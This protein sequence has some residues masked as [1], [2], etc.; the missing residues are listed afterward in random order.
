LPEA[1]LVSE[2]KGF[3]LGREGRE[4]RQV[5]PLVASD[6]QTARDLLSQALAAVQPP[7]YLDLVD[8]AAAPPGLVFQRPFTRMVR[9]AA[10]APGNEK[11]VYCV[12]GP[13]LG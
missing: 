10:P 12:A 5:G 11:L 9:G 1:A 8:P 3:I 4:A 2:G 7:V 6:R 13:E